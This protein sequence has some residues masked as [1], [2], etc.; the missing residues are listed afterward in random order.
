[1]AVLDVDVEVAV[2]DLEPVHVLPRVDVRHARVAVGVRVLADLPVD[3]RGRRVAV[4]EERL[5][6]GMRVLIGRGGGGEE[7]GRRVCL[8]AGVCEMGAERERL[9]ELLSLGEMEGGEDEEDGE[10]HL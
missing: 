2:R 8:V 7:R 3:A 4:A 9:A 1:M 5:R 6:D 10:L